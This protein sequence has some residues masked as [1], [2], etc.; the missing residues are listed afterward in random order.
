MLLVQSFADKTLGR[1]NNMG[2]PLYQGKAERI[3]Y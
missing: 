1:V 2:R 3:F